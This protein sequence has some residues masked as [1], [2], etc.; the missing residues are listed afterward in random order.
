VACVF[1]DN[2]RWIGRGPLERNTRVFYTIE[3]WVDVYETWRDDI[4]KKRAAGQSVPVEVVEGR[5]L[6]NSVLP[7]IQGPDRDRVYQLGLSFYP[8]SKPQ[9]AVPPSVR[10]QK[11]KK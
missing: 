8:L 3:A 9:P 6:L 11:E 4:S 10:P 2:D 5:L 7:R 1:Q